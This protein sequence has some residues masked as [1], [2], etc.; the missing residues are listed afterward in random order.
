MTTEQLT[1]HTIDTLAI[2]DDQ[3]MQIV[4]DLDGHAVSRVVRS[5][6]RHPREPLH[7]KA[8]LHIVRLQN[9]EA[10]TETYLLR[11]RNI[12]AGGI[13]FLH[14]QEMCPGTPC[15][16]GIR[17]TE[18][19]MVLVVGHVVRTRQLKG[20]VEP[21]FEVGIEFNKPIDIHRFVPHC[22]TPQPEGR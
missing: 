11:L 22:S 1:D 3:W 13:G 20:Q 8:A 14:G 6:R 7:E 17:T 10:N 12:S 21:I 19:H 18:G 16:V 15:T 4:A 5:R 9:P 2:T